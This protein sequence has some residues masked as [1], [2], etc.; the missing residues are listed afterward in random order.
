MNSN[1][2]TIN[3]KCSKFK[4]YFAPIIK[5]SGLQL[6]NCEKCR[7]KAKKSKNKMCEHGKRKTQCNECV[8]NAI[9]MSQNYTAAPGGESPDQRSPPGPSRRP[10][11][12]GHQVPACTVQP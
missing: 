11:F 1:I 6:K 8:C 7:G 10:W 4:C 2:D 12:T 9:M 3:P 5:S